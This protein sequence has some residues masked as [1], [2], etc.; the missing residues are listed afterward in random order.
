[1]SGANEI[2]IVINGSSVLSLTNLCKQLAEAFDGRGA[3]YGNSI[4]FIRELLQSQSA[5]SQI[6]ILIKNSDSLLVNFGYKQTL[7]EIENQYGAVPT[8]SREDLRCRMIDA[9]TQQGPTLF[10]SLV[11]EVRNIKGVQLELA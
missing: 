1:M 5:S 9:A 11:E 3:S 6:L 8:S 10:D 4:G 7:K 2:Q